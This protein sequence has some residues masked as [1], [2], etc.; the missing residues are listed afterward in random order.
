M[1]SKNN[2]G[3]RVKKHLKS[4]DTH[5]DTDDNNINLYLF[6]KKLNINVY[7]YFIK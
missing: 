4:K 1:E 2:R 5:M 3:A 7:Q 6:C